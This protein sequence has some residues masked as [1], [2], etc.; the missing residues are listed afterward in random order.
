MIAS[1]LMPK[2]GRFF[3]RKSKFGFFVV[4]L[5][6][7]SIGTVPEAR[8]IFL[9]E[10]LVDRMEARRD[11]SSVATPTWLAW[12]GVWTAAA[13]RTAWVVGGGGDYAL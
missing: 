5:N 12:E 11:G 13:G 6:G 1:W 8:D 9:Q 7:P 10:S 3:Q 2:C 4:Y